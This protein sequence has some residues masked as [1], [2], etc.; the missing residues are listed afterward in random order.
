[1]SAQP[2]ATLASP[3]APAPQPFEFRWRRADGQ[4]TVLN[5]FARNAAE[6][7]ES[8]RR[9]GWPGH[10]GTRLGR[11]RAW[12]RHAVLSELPPVPVPAD[13]DATIPAPLPAPLAAPSPS[14]A[15]RT[16]AEGTG[17]ASGS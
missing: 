11:Y 14:A 16:G 9:A 6:A 4:V 17:A 15:D 7:E 2:D 12:L 5:C 8:A 10:D 3:T 13:P 1:M